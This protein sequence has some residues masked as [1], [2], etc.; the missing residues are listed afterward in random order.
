VSVCDVASAALERKSVDKPVRAL[1]V[2]LPEPPSGWSQ[3]SWRGLSSDTVTA[4]R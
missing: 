2:R 1:V 4:P 3:T